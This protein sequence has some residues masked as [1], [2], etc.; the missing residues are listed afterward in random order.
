M[1]LHFFL[2]RQI[3]S[4]GLR[5]TQLNALLI[6]KTAGSRLTHRNRRS[7]VGPL[8]IAVYGPSC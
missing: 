6:T 8:C 2:K 1:G 4:I 5:Q 7:F 3:N